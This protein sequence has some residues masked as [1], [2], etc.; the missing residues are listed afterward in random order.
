[1]ISQFAKPRWADR[2]RLEAALAGA[3]E[4]GP[5]FAVHGDPAAVPL[6][7]QDLCEPR[8]LHSLLRAVGQQIGT[9]EARVAASTLQYGL[10]ARC[11]SLVLGAWRCEG[12]VIDSRGL[13]YIATAPGSV[14]LALT[15]L[16]AWDCTSLAAEEVAE[17]IADTVI[18]D[19]L[20][21]LHAAVRTAVRVADGLLWGN[22]A[23]ALVSASHTVA[24]AQP[25]EQLT[26]VTTAILSRAPLADRLTRTSAGGVRRRSCCLWYRSQHRDNCGDCPLTD[27]PVMQAAP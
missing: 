27:R 21:G 2:G 12:L 8:R 24:L 20:T 9:S 3:A 5:Y 18:A 23:S 19:Q 10:A 11:W 14:E 26:V 17:V 7:Q 6:S 16:R 4:F 1:M 22:A 15:D 25:S 13:R